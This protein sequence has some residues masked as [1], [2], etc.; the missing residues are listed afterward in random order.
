MHARS[1]VV[2]KALAIAR[3]AANI[4][5]AL[6]VRGRMSSH[7]ENNLNKKFAFAAAA[8]LSLAASVASAEPYVSGAVGASNY[9]LDEGCGW[10]N[11]DTSPLGYR[12]IGGYRFGSGLSVEALYTDFGEMDLSEYGSGLKVKGTSF[13][14]GL[15]ASGE[16]SPLWSGVVRLGLTSNKLKAKGYGIFYGSMD[17]SDIRPYFG[18]GVGY[19]VTPGT[20]I[21][22]S[23]DFTRFELEGER[24]D[25][26]LVSIGLRQSF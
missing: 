10:A 26:R 22:L 25:A 15:A 21:E 14:V 16:F 5:A 20:T 18:V 9:R 24:A 3:R 8:V 1:F 2:A 17:E 13:G 7:R 6:I 23:A 11:C 12:L 4:R 19:N